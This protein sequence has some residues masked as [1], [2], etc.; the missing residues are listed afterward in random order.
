MGEQLPSDRAFQEDA[1]AITYFSLRVAIIVLVGLLTV[2][3]LREDHALAGGVPLGSISAAWYTP[4]QS[5]VVA[6]L[7]GVG[8]AMI[9]LRGRGVQ[10]PF[11]NFAG[12]FAPVVAFVPT[13]EPVRGPCFHRGVDPGLVAQRTPAVEGRWTAAACEEFVA[14]VD[15]AMVPY[16]WVCSVVLV[17]VLGYVL[18]RRRNPALVYR[19]AGAS[20]WLWFRDRI[21]HDDTREPSRGEEVV[22]VLLMIVVWAA[23][24]AWYGVDRTSFVLRAHTLAATF[25]FLPTAVVA[26]LAGAAAGRGRTAATRRFSRAGRGVTAIAYVAVAGA[27]LLG[28]TVAVGA[29]LLG[30]PGAAGRGLWSLEWVLVLGF[31]GFWCIQT[32]EAGIPRTGARPAPQTVV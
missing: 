17:A 22:G 10:E 1:A 14:R 19:D 32:F 24:I 12:L 2:A 5:V 31:L 4:A 25:V 27:M 28:I 3:V 26:L 13:A 7:T 8:A 23:L 16:F 20:P 6:A 15:G 11:L 18:V 30:L 9:A 21:L 29:R